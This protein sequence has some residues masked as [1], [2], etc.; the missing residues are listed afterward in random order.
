MLTAKFIAS[1]K[2]AAPGTRAHY[3]DTLVPGL[4]LRVTDR[5]AKSFVVY[6]RWGGSAPA[7]R[8]L[9]SHKALTLAEARDR[10]REWIALAERG[11]DPAA[12][13]RA[14]MVAE[15]RRRH[16]TFQAVTEA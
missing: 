7:R 4:G 3:W 15:Q 11:I 12:Q 10:A 1:L 14:A 6:R 8:T 9:G 2:P 16:T 5:G 13:R